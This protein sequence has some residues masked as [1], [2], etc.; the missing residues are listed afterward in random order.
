MIAAQNWAAALRA[1]AV[2]E[3]R[4]SEAGTS[5]PATRAAA[6]HVVQFAQEELNALF[7][8]WSVLYG[9]SN[10]YRRFIDAP[11]LILRDGR[12]ILA[13]KV[14]DLRSIVSIH[15]QPQID[16]P[17]RLQLEL[18]KVS[19]GRLRLPDAV[20]TRYRQQ[21]SDSI[22]R[23]LPRWRGSAMISA[24]GAANSSAVAAAM[25]TLLLQVF[26]NQPGEAVLFL[27]LADGG[28]S[29][30]VKLTGVEIQEGAMKLTVEPLTMAERA[31]LLTRLRSN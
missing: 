20:W 25:S 28:D 23:Q 12:I 14:H 29:V 10:K 11:T 22:R 9:W 27:P 3:S 18:L 5:R 1:D 17:G 13:G 4:A 2:R 6:T 21:L 19:G 24:N 16:E 26:S 30:P 15:L 7:E 31:A 8:K